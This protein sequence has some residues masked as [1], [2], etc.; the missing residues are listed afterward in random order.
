M[1]DAPQYEWVVVEV[2][3]FPIPSQKPVTGQMTKDRALIE[4]DVFSQNNLL[5]GVTY[6][7]QPREVGE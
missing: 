2:F 4:R 6:E 1:S 5:P 7:I 3:H